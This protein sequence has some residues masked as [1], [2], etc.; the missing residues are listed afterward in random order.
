MIEFVAVIREYPDPLQWPITTF[1]LFIVYFASFA[2]AVVSLVSFTGFIE[3]FSLFYCVIYIYIYSLL[4]LLLLERLVQVGLALRSIDYL[5]LLSLR[6]KKKT[7]RTSAIQWS[8][9]FVHL[10]QSREVKQQQQ[11]TKKKNMSAQACWFLLCI[12]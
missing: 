11:Q 1:S 10:S 9:Q 5:L 7:E 2:S 12:V 6:E 4:L 3:S 8:F